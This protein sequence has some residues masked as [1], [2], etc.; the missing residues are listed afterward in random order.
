MNP[1]PCIISLHDTLFYPMSHHFG[2]DT[3]G[4]LS[5][6][7]FI[8]MDRTIS[9]PNISVP[10]SLSP[11]LS[12]S[13]TEHLGPLKTS[14]LSRDPV[15]SPACAYRLISSHETVV[16][17]LTRLVTLIWVLK[18]SRTNRRHSSREAGCVCGKKTFWTQLTDIVLLFHP[19]SV[20]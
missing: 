13:W 9:G 19:V 18:L 16:G 11:G 4:L 6:I 5:S 14:V 7:S 10:S 2:C 12:L 8:S 3:H 20:D 17:L 1:L 15:M